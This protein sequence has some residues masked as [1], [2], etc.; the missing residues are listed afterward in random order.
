MCRRVYEEQL[1]NPQFFEMK[2]KERERSLRSS[3]NPNE[4]EKKTEA[5][6]ASQPSPFE[7]ENWKSLMGGSS[8]S[9]LTT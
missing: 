2:A 7:S 3:V 8:H 5:D 6:S 1:K 4:E 9:S